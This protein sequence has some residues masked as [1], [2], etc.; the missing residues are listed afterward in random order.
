M[1]STSLF[2]GLIFGSVGVGFFVYGKK[3]KKIMAL[4]SG[5]A[6]CVIPYAVSNVIVLT[7]I[8]IALVALPFV[9][10]Q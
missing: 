10:R 5:V 9:Y 1:D 4:I 7:L 6:L 2:L 8:G 3:Q